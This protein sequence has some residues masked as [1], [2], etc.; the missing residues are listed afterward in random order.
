MVSKITSFAVSQVFGGV[1]ALLTLSLLKNGG[2]HLGLVRGL[3]GEFF[4][5]LRSL[6]MKEPS[7]E[8]QEKMGVV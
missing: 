5:R 3:E 2:H 6:C 4:S 8:V 1:A 7:L